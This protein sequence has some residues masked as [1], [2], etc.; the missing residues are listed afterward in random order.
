MARPKI[1]N[2]IPLDKLREF[3]RQEGERSLLVVRVKPNAKIEKLTKN[4]AEEIILSVRAQAV[5]GQANQRVIE[6]VAEIFSLPKSRVTIVS[7]QQ[8]RIKTLAITGLKS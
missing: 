8:A 6:L 1:V 3:L 2:E 7:G 4:E 5:E